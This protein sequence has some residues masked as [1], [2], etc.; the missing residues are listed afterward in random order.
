MH[1]CRLHGVTVLIVLTLIV[2]PLAL[3]PT[4]SAVEPHLHVSDWDVAWPLLAFLLLPLVVGIL[5][6]LRWSD[7]AQEAAR[8][9][10]PISVTCLLLHITLYFY[11]AWS[12]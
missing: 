11:A 5:V 10:N 1:R 9:F 2:L 4:V 12:A 3:P 7:A 8:F 6:R